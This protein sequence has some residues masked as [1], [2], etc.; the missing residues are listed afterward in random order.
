MIIIGRQIMRGKGM[1]RDLGL[2]GDL[3]EEFPDL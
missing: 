1:Y 2:I 3:L